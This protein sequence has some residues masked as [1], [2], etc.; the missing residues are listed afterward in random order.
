MIKW[1]KKKQAVSDT[2]NPL[3]RCH[4]C[5]KEVELDSEGRLAA[6]EWKKSCGFIYECGLCSGS[7]QFQLPYRVI[8][9]K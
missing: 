9:G 7:F 2:L 5:G 8:D 4:S 3:V 6:H 1:F